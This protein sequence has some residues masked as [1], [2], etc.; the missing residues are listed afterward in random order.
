MDTFASLASVGFAVALTGC[1]VAIWPKS[2]RGAV[3]RAGAGGHAWTDQNTTAEAMRARLRQM[4]RPMLRLTATNQPRFSKIGGTPDLAGGMRWPLGV[5]GPR[6]FLMQIDLREARTAGG[7]DWLPTSGALYAF[8]DPAEFLSG[9]EVRLRFTRELGLKPRAF[10]HDLP[11][12]QR[13]MERRLGMTAAASTPSAAW[14][15]IAPGAALRQSLKDALGAPCANTPDHRLGGYPAELLPSQLALECEHLSRG[16]DGSVYDGES[17]EELRRAAEDWRLL[18]QIDADRDLGLEYGDRGRFYV[19][20]REE[21]ARR[22][23]FSKT[24][25]ISQSY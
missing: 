10:P 12:D 11:D 17:L 21:D 25:T 9:N 13:F 4:S 14:L 24:I 8:L 5:D 1:L 15:D 16:L 20:I 18:L 23:H 3:R 2:R 19:F 22:G 6:A 7:P